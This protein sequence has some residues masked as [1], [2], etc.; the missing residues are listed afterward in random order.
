MA[1]VSY[2]WSMMETVFFCDKDV[3][4]DTITGFGWYDENGQVTVNTGYMITIDYVSAD[5]KNCTVTI[6]PDK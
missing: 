5:Q 6:L 4:D 2:G 3:I 1:N